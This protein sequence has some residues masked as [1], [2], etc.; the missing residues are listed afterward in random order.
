MNILIITQYFFP[1]VFRIN[2]IAAGL[3]EKGHNVT[4]YTGIPNY[5]NGN[6]FK[7]YGLLGPYTEITNGVKVIRVP[8]VSRGQNKGIRLMINY[9]SFMIIAT[10]LAPVLC[11]GQFDK[12]FVYQLSPVTSA[13]PALVLK[14]IKKIPI[15]FWVTDLWPET[16]EATGAVK[17]TKMLAY[18]GK[19]VKF[20]YINSNSILV[21]SKG[22]IDKISQR[23]IEKDKITYWPQWG[24]EIFAKQHI[25]NEYIAKGEIPE[26][27]KIMFAGNIGSSQGFETI[28]DAAEKLKNHK[29]I[30]WI[31]VGNGIK[32]KWL[33][34]E[35]KK[36]HLQD[37]IYLLG[38]KPFETMPTY[39][40]KSD[41]L[42]AS[43][44]ANPLFSITVPAK[45]QSY[46]P[47]GKPIL[48][49]MNG[50][51]SE[52]IKESR[53]GVTCAASNSDELAAGALELYNSTK[54]QRDE[55]GLNGRNFFLKHFQRKDLLDQL[56]MILQTA[57]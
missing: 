39:Y 41:V 25:N 50:E 17:S 10:L 34:S 24:E 38:S 57:T 30:K 20:L 28:V 32:Y 56:E 54:A 5:P 49:S 46:L 19:F 42:L 2:D 45:I 51:G 40:S 7:G 13:L 12:I 9:L 47:S 4:V 27:F 52:L 6:F 55:M 21:T 11:R 37:C 33:E 16:L 43:L 36:R 23:G 48:V 29:V 22:F 18:W 35:I 44:N 15:I 26:G 53:S 1:E 3:V 14:W 31:I 8:L